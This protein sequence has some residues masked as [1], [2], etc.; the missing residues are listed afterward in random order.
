MEVGWQDRIKATVVN[1]KR[2]RQDNYMINYKII[3]E[4]EGTKYNGW[5]K[6]GN[7]DNTIQGKL[8]SVLSKMV[9][10]EVEVNGSGR[11]DAGTHAMAQA[12]NFKLKNAA[13]NIKEYLNKYLPMDIR[14]LSCEVVDE[15]FHARLNSK[16]KKYVYRICVGEKPSVFERRYVYHYP[17]E[18]DIEK[19]RRAS[20]CLIGE[21]DFRAFSTGK[22]TKKSA[23]RNIYDIHI[24]Q[25]DDEV[26]FMYYGNGFLHNMVRILTGTLL[27]VGEGK[28]EEQSISET[29][30]SK[31]RVNAGVTVPAHGLALVEVEY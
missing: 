12:A 17:A 1:D 5:Q 4:Y 24:E 18:L 13:D 11:T 10:Y 14:V 31:E 16:S 19:M 26:R 22:K 3:L 15:R 20:R 25:I 28:R 6:Q 30:E 9:G 23:V 21:F 27:E 7:T 8:E 29:L 2:K